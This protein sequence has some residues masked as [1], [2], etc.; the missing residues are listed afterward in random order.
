MFADVPK[1]DNPQFGSKILSKVGKSSLH[2][3]DDEGGGEERRS[4]KRPSTFSQ[5]LCSPAK[6]PFLSDASPTFKS[7]PLINDTNSDRETV[8]KQSL[9][10]V[11]DLTD[12]DSLLIDLTRPEVSAATTSTSGWSFSNLNP[13]IERKQNTIRRLKEA[14]SRFFLV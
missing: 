1:T 8:K 7:G 5:Q 12:S 9:P 2:S 13:S 11:V 10:V 4:L 3:N 6:R 14:A